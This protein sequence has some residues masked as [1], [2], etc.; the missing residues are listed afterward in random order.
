MIQILLQSE[1]TYAFMPSLIKRYRDIVTE[2]QR[3]KDIRVYINAI[4]HIPWSNIFS[5]RK[6]FEY[7]FIYHTPL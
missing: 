1:I 3:D 2:E 5:I 7:F 4:R 6:I